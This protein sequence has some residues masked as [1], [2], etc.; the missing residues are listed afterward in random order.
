MPPPGSDDPTIPPSQTPTV[1]GPWT[2]PVHRAI[3]AHL[4]PG[5]VI[6]RYRVESVLGE[7]GMGV[8]YLARQDKP[9][10]EVAL[11]VVRPGYATEK[12]LRRFEHESEVLGRLLHPGIAQIYEAGTADAGLGPQPFFA[13]E[14]VK[15]D[16]LT[17]YASDHKLSTRARLELLAKVCDAVQH[18]HQKGVIHRDLKP[19]NILVTDEGQPKILDFGVARATDSDIQQTTMQ[20]D[21]GAIVGT[22]PYMSPEQVGGDPDELDT[23]SDVYALGV[24][25]YELLVGRLPYD[26]ER[27]MIHE[28]ARIIKEEE[29]T[30]LSSIDRTLRGD[31]ETIVAHALE[32]DKARRYGAASALA[33]DIRRYLS[34]EPIA[35]RPASTWYQ[36]QKFSRRNRSLVGGVVAS[37]LILLLGLGGTAWQARIAGSER[38]RADE[39]A[40]A[41]AAA[42]AE[43][44]RLALAE[45]SQRRLADEQRD[46][47]EEARKR[48]EAINEFVTTSLQSSDPNQ[49][50]AQAMTVAEAMTQALVKLDSGDLKDQPAT[51][52][53]LLRTIATILHGIGRGA[54]AVA[55]AERALNIE[56]ELHSGDHEDVAS[57]LNIL[58]VVRSS[59]ASVAEAES[60]HLLALEIRQRLFKGDHPGI[61]ASLHNL[62]RVRLLLGRAAEA[63]PLFVQSLEMYQRLFPGDH[64]EVAVGLNSV[65]DVWLL[66]GR[67]ADAEPML[68]QALE[69]Y[70]QLYKSDHPR[71]AWCLCRLATVRMT[72]GRP[73]EAEPLFTQALEMQ[74]RLFPGDHPAI[75]LSLNELGLV[76][77][78]LGRAAEAEPMHMQSLEMRQ[79]LFKGDHPDVAVSLN[80]VALVRFVL[81]R[82]AE[83]EPPLTQALE[84]QQRLFNGDH[85]DLLTML[86]NVAILREL[87]GRA[88]DAEPLYIQAVEM[89]RRLNQ[90]YG[91][92]MAD[93]LRN[94]AR[95]LVA[96]GR[97]P[98][99]LARA[100]EA[101][102]MAAQSLP[103]G[104]PLRTKCDHMLAQIKKQVED[105]AGDSAASK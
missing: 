32:K 62:A 49:G 42:E 95:C 99:A 65:A 47:A 77:Q 19:G 11:K 98:E 45:A 38:D 103:E 59:L 56:R 87:L 2:S 51:V 80:N 22:I 28:A 26:L 67:P 31:V 17:R 5:A 85:P 44:R 104:D 54:D 94:L 29:P 72:L 101:A 92:D 96:L 75:A 68:L 105:K 8:V 78:S 83:A 81:G 18:A 90:G 52:A 36:V 7:G 9:D 14:L 63:E 30:R 76:L 25:A 41:A 100:Q 88:A 93:R 71:V 46:A 16:S 102:D 48:A 74:R 40:V 91:P 6:S 79:R 70:H 23:R 15:G 34:D 50:G 58:G 13:M 66:L 86:T 39:K 57:S 12:M 82:V 69:M 35:A 97:L 61:A 21:V 53:G 64:P 1:S 55:P 60:L 89:A 37:F 33:A 10:R 84:M 43:Q 20:T 73:A 4:A 3:P 27:K 24:I